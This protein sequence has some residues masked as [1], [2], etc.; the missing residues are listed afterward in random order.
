MC[1]YSILL[2]IKVLFKNLYKAIFSLKKFE[3]PKKGQ[4]MFLGGN[5]NIKVPV[6][7]IC[8]SFHS[9]PGFQKCPYGSG[10]R[11]R[12]GSKEVNTKEEKLHQQIFY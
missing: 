3:N 5:Y 11:S 8:I 7:R 1:W 12:F 9:D 10:W 6:F 4:I 2:Q